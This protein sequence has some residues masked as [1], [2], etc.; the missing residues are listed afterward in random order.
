MEKQKVR[1]IKNK[2]AAEYRND[3]SPVGQIISRML[4]TDKNYADMMYNANRKKIR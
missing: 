3:K 2:Y 4:G 1:D